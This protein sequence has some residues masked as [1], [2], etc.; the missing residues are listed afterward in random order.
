[1]A[2]LRTLAVLQLRMPGFCGSRMSQRLGYINAVR[3]KRKG[4]E[5]AE[6]K[7]PGARPG[8]L[9]QLAAFF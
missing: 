8:L 4:L 2:G 7:S 3:S 6:T 9:S 1:M 5:M